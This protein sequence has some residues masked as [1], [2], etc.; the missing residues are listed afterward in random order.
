MTKAEEWFVQL[1]S[2]WISHLP[3]PFWF[4]VATAAAL[5]FVIIPR[6]DE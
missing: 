4:P 5:A 2:Q 3:N 6:A 1:A